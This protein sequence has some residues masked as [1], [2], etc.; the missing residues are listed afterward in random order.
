MGNV[1]KDVT[2]G[3]CL[4]WRELWITTATRIYHLATKDT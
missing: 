3:A 1:K 2:D 4:V